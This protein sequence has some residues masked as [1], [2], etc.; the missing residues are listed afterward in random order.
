[1]PKVRGRPAL[2]DDAK[3]HSVS[4]RATP[5]MMAKLD[6]AVAASGRSL[7][8]EVEAQV[9]RALALEDLLGGPRRLTFL[10]F[11]GQQLLAAEERHGQLWDEDQETWRDAFATV[12]MAMKALEPDAREAAKAAADA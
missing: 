4:F 12:M 5:E 11:L 6:A 1:M 2:G 8:Q 9:Q 7:A 3:R 10:A